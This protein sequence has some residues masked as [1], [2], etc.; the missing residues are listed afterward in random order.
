[1]NERT[2]SDRPREADGAEPPAQRPDRAPHPD[3]Y[4]PRRLYAAG[5]PAA[6]TSALQVFPAIHARLRSIVRELDPDTILEV[7]PGNRPIAEGPK[8]T[9]LDLSH[10]L[11]RRL[12]GA[13]VEADLLACPFVD[14][15]F[16]LAIAADVLTHVPAAHHPRAID[17]LARI[18][19]HLLIFHPEPSAL[20]LAP[21]L[22]AAT[23]H[24]TCLRC[25]L[26]ADLWPVRLPS[27]YGV[28]RFGII[29]ATPA[30]R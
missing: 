3:W 2:R 7:G 17:E 21:P 11:L 26:R 14:H 20:A 19:R 6:L 30:E 16:D 15:A 8:V 28:F 23:L 10:A 1:M 12:S 18:A 25:G 27:P 5:Y 24:E 4:A 22:R 29:V 9:Y 13:R